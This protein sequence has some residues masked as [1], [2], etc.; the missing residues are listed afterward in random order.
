MPGCNLLSGEFA[1]Q[2]SMIRNPASHPL[3]KV[4]MAAGR[5]GGAVDLNRLSIN[6]VVDDDEEEFEPLFNYSQTV[7][8]APTFLSDESDNDEVIFTSAPKRRPEIQSSKQSAAAPQKVP[9][10]QP[11]LDDDDDSWLMS[12]PP[13][14]PKQPQ[15]EIVTENCALQLLREKRRELMLLEQKASPGAIRNIEEL[16]R[17]E[18]QYRPEPEPPVIVKAPT[19][20]SDESLT[21]EAA[22]TGKGKILL[23]VQN[24]AENS[25]SIRIYTTDKFEKLFTVYAKMAKAPL[26]NMTFRFDGDQLSPNST[27][28]EHDMEDGDIIEVHDKR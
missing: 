13:K 23:K 12:L 24:K 14:Q 8:P 16:A 15:P 2:P 4:P 10:R 26:A 22:A 3:V 18:A 28:E 7:G 11:N 6:H 1:L 5:G 25:Q 19:T 21:G 9:A 17:M 20:K 27:P